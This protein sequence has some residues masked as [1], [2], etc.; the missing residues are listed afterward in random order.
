VGNPGS[1]DLVM[2]K[3]RV[4][5]TFDMESRA[6]PFL[7]VPMSTPKHVAVVN[8]KNLLSVVVRPSEE[9]S[10]SI[11]L[12]I[13]PNVEDVHTQECITIRNGRDPGTTNVVR[14]PFRASG[15]AQEQ[16]SKVQAGL[17]ALSARSK[18]EPHVLLTIDEVIGYVNWPAFSYRKSNCTSDDTAKKLVGQYVGALRIA[19]HFYDVESIVVALNQN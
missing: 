10:L 19:G 12:M 2:P 3:I 11:V 7:E 16:A 9:N 5:G 18:S 17:G 8:K 6:G 14:W 13:C 15:L 1:D 4:D